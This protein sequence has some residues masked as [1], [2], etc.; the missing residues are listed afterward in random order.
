MKRNTHRTRIVLLLIAIGCLSTV[1]KANSVVECNRCPSTANAAIAKGAGLTVVADFENAQLTA[2]NVEYDRELRRWRTYR[3]PI[4]AQISSAFYRLLEAAT[5]TGMRSSPSRIRSIQPSRAAEGPPAGRSSNKPR[6]GLVVTVHPDNPEYSNPVGVSFPE[7]YKDYSASDVILSATSRTQ[8]GRDLAL[9]LAGANTSSAAWNSIALTLQELTLSW[10]SAFGADGI[11]INVTWRDG[12]K[13]IY[14]IDVD[15]VAEA[16]YV[17]GESRDRSGN[18]LPDQSITSPST[19]PS[20]VGHYD[21]GEGPSGAKD[22]ER[23]IESARMYGVPISRSST[24]Y[25]RISCG[26]DG[27]NLTCMRY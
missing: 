26:W 11:I 4:P 10:S 3:A 19:A 22:L 12:S 18:K 23:W 8:L 14:R 6:G 7:A 21:F 5:A 9:D 17:H 13:T 16:R 20:Y 25:D 1:A 27:R 2:Y 24:S 15:N